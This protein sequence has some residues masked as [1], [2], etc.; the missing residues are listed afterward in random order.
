AF[1]DHLAAMEDPAWDALAK[2]F[3][4]FLGSCL[5]EGLEHR[6]RFARRLA[7]LVRDRI[8]GLWLK[9]PE[10][11]DR[12]R[13]E[14]LGSFGLALAR[15]LCRRDAPVPRVHEEESPG[16][17]NFMDA[18]LA[19]PETGASQGLNVFCWGGSQVS[20][21]GLCVLHFLHSHRQGTRPLASV[22]TLLKTL[23]HSPV[24]AASVC[25]VLARG[26][27]PLAAFTGSPSHGGG[28]L[29]LTSHGARFFVQ[30]L[31]TPQYLGRAFE[32][33]P[34]VRSF[35]RQRLGV[36]PGRGRG[37][38]GTWLVAGFSL[39]LDQ[40]KARLAQ[41]REQACIE[42]AQMGWPVSELFLRVYAQ[43]LGHVGKSC[44]KEP[45]S[46]PARKL[47]QKWKTMHQEAK[48]R[49]GQKDEA[50]PQPDRGESPGLI[51]LFPQADEC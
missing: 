41:A 11:E 24:A 9:T 8:I 17:E 18:G 15:Q 21:A 6:N 7:A 14:T 50:N 12:F 25:M 23:G 34:E 22:A 4:A 38:W 13:L 1:A 26:S 37:H 16:W 47:L 5:P 51:R 27:R 31:A 45:R 20:L 43:G 28:L 32:E 2:N 19:L 39:G 36:R 46:S 40:E 29:S 33:I 44:R 10:L 49:L 30:K 48:R 3:C 42:A 35:A